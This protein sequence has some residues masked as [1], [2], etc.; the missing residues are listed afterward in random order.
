MTTLGLSFII[1]LAILAQVAV[2]AGMAFFR[3]WER[4]QAL[5][6]RLEGLPQTPPVAPLTAPASAPSV[7]PE[8][9]A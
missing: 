7:P 9:P 2:F 3:H 1:L 5:R 4:Y 8:R 6:E